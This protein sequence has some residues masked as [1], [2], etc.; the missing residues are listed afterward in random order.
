MF[1]IGIFGGSFNPPHNGHINIAV[2]AKEQLGLDKMVIMP[3]GTSPHKGKAALGFNTRELMCR[4][5]F[6]RLPGFE[7]TDI[8]GKMA[9]TSYTLNSLRLLKKQYPANAQFYLLIG[10]DMFFSFEKWHKYETILD[11]CNV[12]AAAREQGQFSDMSEYATEI[13]KIKVLNL[14]VTEVSSSQIREKIANGEDISELVPR[15][16]FNI[17]KEKRYY[18]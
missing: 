9:G 18:L 2:Q 7:V 6:G 15:S 17:I 3:T 12:V 14:K 4:L 13:G 8:E 10:A 1:K 5:A 16:V 11:E